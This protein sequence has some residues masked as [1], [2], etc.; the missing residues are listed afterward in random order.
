MILK[1]MWDEIRYQLKNITFYGFFIV[2]LLM[3]F[4]QLGIPTAGDLVLASQKENYYRTQ[5]IT[6]NNKKMEK[7]YFWLGYN[8]ENG[9]VLKH[10]F[11]FNYNAKLSS[12]EKNY[13][14]D[15]IDK[16]YTFD[17]ENNL[18]INVTYDEY[19][20]ILKNLDNNLNGRTI[21]KDPDRYGIYN[22]EISSEN[23]EKIYNDVME[24][25]K[26]TNAY[27][28][29][30]A[31]YMGITAGFFPVFLSTFIF[32]REK[33]KNEYEIKYKS[34]VTFEKY[35]LGKYLG[36]CICIMTCYFLLATYTTLLYFKFSLE[37]NTIIDTL[38]IYKYTLFWVGPTVFFT[39][40]LGMII[41]ALFNKVIIVILAQ[42]I[43]W[44]S[45]I[46]NLAGE[47][48]LLNFVIRFNI[49]GEHEKYI[50]FKGAIIE[51]RIFYTI[52][53]FILVLLSAY[54]W[55]RLNRE[56]MDI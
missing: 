51:N 54:I 4:S 21:Y 9:T 40:A 20:D 14:K 49:F 28:R 34:K 35:I 43:L 48:G 3:F 5:Q 46:K 37:T 23:A 29:L 36:M 19:L 18:S 53:S 2:V 47:Y 45:T 7:M 15:A 42:F 39:T 26:F 10:T 22:E 11:M 16:I 38:A 41:A 55:D 30:F 17:S 31:D 25:D 52:I 56:R 32:V 12:T 50:Q 27:G 24:K 13:L 6:D 1:I 44:S 33:K 8:Y